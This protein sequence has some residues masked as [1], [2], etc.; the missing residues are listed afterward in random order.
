MLIVDSYFKNKKITVMGI[1]LHG[2][3]VGT[4]KFLVAQGAK[5]IATDLRTKE[6]LSVALEKLKGLKNVE[7]V[8]G[9]HRMEDFSKVD[10]V[11]KN[12]AASWSDKHI[13]FALESKVPVE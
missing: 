6:Q 10:M 8:L 4:V 11:I 5:V 3:G 13:K 12:P 2:G 7:Y 9:H 1:G